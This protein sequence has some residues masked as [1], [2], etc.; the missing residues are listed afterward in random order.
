MGDGALFW[1]GPAVR[2]GDADYQRAF[3]QA[4]LPQ[5][6]YDVVQGLKSRDIDPEDAVASIVLFWAGKDAE[7]WPLA[8]MDLNLKPVYTWPSGRDM[9]D[10]ARDLLESRGMLDLVNPK[11]VA[12][13]EADRKMGRDIPRGWSVA[14]A[15]F[16]DPRWITWMWR[17]AVVAMVI[18]LLAQAL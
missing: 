1:Q 9:S 2:W 7:A 18:Y 15:I 6:S 3:M 10:A 11:G 13:Q 8:A 16:Y 12:A 14:P 5:P 4:G 17:L